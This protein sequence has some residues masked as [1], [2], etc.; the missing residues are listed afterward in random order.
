MSDTIPYMFRHFFLKPNSKAETDK[1]KTVE[2]DIIRNG[3]RI[4]LKAPLCQHCDDTGEI[5]I[6]HHGLAACP[7]CAERKVMDTRNG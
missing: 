3:V 7:F 1:L 5:P 6:P 4:E 2:I